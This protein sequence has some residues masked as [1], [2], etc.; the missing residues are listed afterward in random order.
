MTNISLQSVDGIAVVMID[1]PERRNALALE[2]WED[3]GE[4]LGV[5]MND[6]AARTIILTGTPGHFCA[7]ADIADM[8][9]N[10]YEEAWRDRKQAAVRKCNM[11]LARG[12][13]P[14]IAAIDGDA[15]GGG[16]GLAL[17]CDFRLASPSA[18][19][20]VTPA[21]LGI[22]YSRFDTK[23]LVDAVGPSEARALLYTANII[24]ADEAEA[25]GLIDRIVDDPLAAA[26]EMAEAMGT[27]SQHSILTAKAHISAIMD[28][29]VDDDEATIELFK[30]AYTRDEFFDRLEAFLN[31]RR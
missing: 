21:K 13:K 22:A 25:I 20:G 5:A 7:G 6:H 31:R 3:L 24:D 12:P 29:A 10:A 19:F 26:G 23:L 30:D 9:E 4:V 8:A 15:I 27:L 2:D 16:C 1:R 14:A 28:G 11:W 17:A 18:R